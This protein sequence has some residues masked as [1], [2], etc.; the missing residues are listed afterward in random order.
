MGKRTKGGVGDTAE[1][2]QKAIL[3][4]SRFALTT[5]MSVDVFF[6]QDLRM[7]ILSI[8]AEDDD[9]SMSYDTSYLDDMTGF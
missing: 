8:N 4:N 6:R 2:A 1:S 9:N 7:Y 5:G 3:R